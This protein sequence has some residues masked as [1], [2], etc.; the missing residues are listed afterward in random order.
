M[1]AADSDEEL[2]FV[3]KDYDDYGMG[4]KVKSNTEFEKVREL[5]DNR[6]FGAAKF[7]AK[8]VPPGGNEA[9]AKYNA[10]QIDDEPISD[11]SS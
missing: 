10:I 3:N 5:D 7:N 2:A 6:A 8:E 4:A 1:D 11:D 9:L